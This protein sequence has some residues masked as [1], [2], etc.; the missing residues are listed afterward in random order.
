MV[1]Y[2][3]WDEFAVKGWELASLDPS[4]TR[5]LLKWSTKKKEFK[6]KVTSGPKTHTYFLSNFEAEFNRVKQFSLTM[7]R[8]LTH[9]EESKK[10]K[11]KQRSRQ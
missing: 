8:L 4:K 9:S 3:D 5:W 7:T 10:S 1:K 11:K 2:K 6:V